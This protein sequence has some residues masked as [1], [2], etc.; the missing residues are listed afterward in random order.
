MCQ[1]YPSWIFSWNFAKPQNGPLLFFSLPSPFVCTCDF[2][3][4]AY[5]SSSSSQSYNLWAHPAA[6]SLCKQQWRQ[7][8]GQSKKPAVGGVARQTLVTVC[9]TFWGQTPIVDC[10]RV[11]CALILMPSLSLSL[12][13]VVSCY[14]H[15]VLPASCCSLCD[16][17]KRG[18]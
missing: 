7:G 13:I 15:A 4:V 5:S 11:Q 6:L 1:P 8:A 10:R 3:L 17:F 16:S 2:M 12:S 18:N 14:H 9:F